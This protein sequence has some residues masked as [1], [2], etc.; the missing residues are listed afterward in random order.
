LASAFLSSKPASSARVTVI[1]VNWNRKN[2][3]KPCIDSLA[4][5]AHPSFQVVV[6]DNGS[7]DGSPELVRAMAPAFPV[8][9]TLIENQTNLGFCAANNQGIEQSNSEFVALLNN[10]AEADPNWL[11]A[12]EEA[13]SASARTGMAASKIL[14]W[15]DPK[16]ID[17]CGHLIYPD[18]QNRGRGSGE[19]DRGQFDR[20]EEVLWPDGCAALYRRAML[21]EIGGFD[22]DFF[23]YADDAELGL[24]GR[25]AGWKCLYTPHAVVR[26][27]RGATLG[28]GSA[29]RL[30]LIERNRVLLAVKLF[31]GNLLWLNAGYFGARLAAGLWAALRNRGDLRHYP[32]TTGKATAALALLRGTWSALP[33]IP[34]MLR[35]RRAFRPRHRLSPREI[36]RLLLSHRISLKELTQQGT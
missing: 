14:V 20:V 25:I 7:T 19:M 33:L 24:R 16:V 26:H 2:L 5:Q 32:G 36:R 28:L 11:A 17:K 35:K 6:V 27:H 22:E 3:L 34:R 21:D 15:E 30:T 29:R 13:I 8:P 31:P 4:R 10:D 23:A 12:L 1:V 18:G 9:L